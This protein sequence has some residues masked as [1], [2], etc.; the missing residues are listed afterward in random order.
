MNIENTAAPNAQFEGIQVPADQSFIWRIDDYPWVVNKWNYHPEFELHGIRRG[1]GIAY[2][3]DHI[4][5]FTPGNLYFVGGNLPHD[6]ISSVPSGE[7]IVGRDNVVQFE[8]AQILGAGEFLPELLSVKPLFERAGRG[9][10][11]FG[12]TAKATMDLLER[13]GEMGRLSRL[14]LLIEILDRL[15][16]SDQFEYLASREFVAQHTPGS[17]KDRELLGRIL[18]FVKQ[19]YQSAPSL[20]EAALH[21]GM[22]ENSFSRFF[23]THTG[24][25]FTAH[26]NATKIWK[27]KELLS[28]TSIPITDICF[29][30]GF[31]NISNFN[32]RFRAHV[33]M[34]PSAF[35]KQAQR[36]LEPR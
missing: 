21:V 31:Q 32:R 10:L 19:N 11:F 24:R 27:A 35:R 15:S 23:K 8:Q 30:V 16:Q 36:F 25:S 29:E 12:D 14:S 6:W 18:G 26:I 2:V 20:R 17:E 33:A 28:D 22:S 1:S 7:R 9:L 34:T 3:G 13:M 5:S 4:G